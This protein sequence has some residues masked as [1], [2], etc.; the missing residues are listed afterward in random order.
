[1][2]RANGNGLTADNRLAGKLSFR[3]AASTLF[4]RYGKEL[5][6][7]LLHLCALAFRTDDLLLVVFT[8]CHGLGEPVVASFAYE[9]IQRHKSTPPLC[10]FSNSPHSKAHNSGRDEPFEVLP[11]QANHF[12]VGARIERNFIVFRSLLLI[13]QA[14]THRHFLEQL[15]TARTCS[16]DSHLILAYR[17]AAL[18]SVICVTPAC[19]MNSA[20]HWRSVDHTGV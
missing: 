13:V 6:Y 10:G 5:C 9:F 20:E 2:V 3:S 15:T 4:R 12:A 1:M 14:T 8:D 17:K 16:I 19:D 11:G 7:D 18:E